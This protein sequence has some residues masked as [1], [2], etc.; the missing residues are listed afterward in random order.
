MSDI[1]PRR[2][3]GLSRKARESRAYNLTLAT[4]GLALVTLVLIVL[5]VVGVVGLGPAI[6]TG[7]L[8]AGAGLML[9]RT[10]SS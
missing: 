9:R 5:A 6:V 3:S 1:E 8:A 7:L 10:L 4:G 2:S